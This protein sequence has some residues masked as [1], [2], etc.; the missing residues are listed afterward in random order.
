MKKIYL[1]KGNEWKETFLLNYNF[2]TRL[3]LD[4]NRLVQKKERVS[5]DTQMTPQMIR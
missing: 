3:I 5:K 1:Q 2:D 4:L